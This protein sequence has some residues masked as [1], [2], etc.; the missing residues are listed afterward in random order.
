MRV[1]SSKREPPNRGIFPAMSESDLSPYEQQRLKNIARN[2]ALLASVG[3]TGILSV[4]QVSVNTSGDSSNT[5]PVAVPSSRKRKSDSPPAWMRPAVEGERRSQRIKGLPVVVPDE[6]EA[7]A[8]AGPFDG[9]SEND[10]VD[11]DLEWP[12][13]SFITMCMCLSEHARVN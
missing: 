8:E 6:V 13:G 11:Y 3:V 9:S 2:K 1:P 5:K 7:H 12:I 4:L 10:S